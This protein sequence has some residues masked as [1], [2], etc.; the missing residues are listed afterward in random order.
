M[1]TLDFVQGLRNF[2]GFLA[3]IVVL[4]LYVY[5]VYKI[6]KTLIKKLK[7]T[8]TGIKVLSIAGAIF[9]LFILTIVAF[10]LGIFLMVLITGTSSLH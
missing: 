7:G 9:L 10:W 4:S 5:A 8:E 1:I 6:M 3:F 2:A